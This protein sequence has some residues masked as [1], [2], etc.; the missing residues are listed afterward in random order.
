MRA[1]LLAVLFAAACGSN[2]LPPGD[3]PG[4]DLAQ[5]RSDLAGFDAA[6]LSCDALR[7]E[8]QAA[9]AQKSCGRDGDC[10]EVDTACG[11]PADC[12]APVNQTGKALLDQIA[13]AYKAGG[14]D[15]AALCGPCPP[16]PVQEVG[17]VQGTCAYRPASCNQL[18]GEVGAFIV[19]R[20]MCSSA[21]DC[22]VTAT[23]CGLPGVCGAYLRKDALPD[24]EKLL[25][26]WSSQGCENGQPC[27]GCAQPL[28]ADCKSG[29]CGP[30][31]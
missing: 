14:C 19:Q 9:F 12:G 10:A 17:C 8:A 29:R 2:G 26:A 18:R 30:K 31:N 20:N 22:T 11:L 13:A 16:P 24:L 7:A 25:L 1:P 27:P 4:P 23:G 21:A 15:A 6:G 28:E 3:D 5:A